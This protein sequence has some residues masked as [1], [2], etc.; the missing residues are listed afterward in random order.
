MIAGI[1]DVG[2]QM[3]PKVGQIWQYNTSHWLVLRKRP[4]AGFDVYNIKSGV[5]IWSY[6]AGPMSEWKL[7]QEA[8]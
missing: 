5:I 6:I 1:K 3:I 8:P 4:E 2:F 7:I